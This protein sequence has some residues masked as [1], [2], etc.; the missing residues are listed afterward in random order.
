MLLKL[1]KRTTLTAPAVLTCSLS[2]TSAWNVFWH[3]FI[4]A[5]ESNEV[6]VVR[7]TSPAHLLQIVDVDLKLKTEGRVLFNSSGAV[8]FAGSH[9]TTGGAGISNCD[10][11]TSSRYRTVHHN[12]LQRRVHSASRRCCGYCIDLVLAALAA[13]RLCSVSSQRNAGYA[14]AGTPLSGKMYNTH[15]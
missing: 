10:S 7:L 9:I 6:T 11:T 13:G 4:R 5:R 2:A 1:V 3:D 8:G 12:I 15:Q 14:T